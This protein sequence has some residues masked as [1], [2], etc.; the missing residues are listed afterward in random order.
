MATRHIGGSGFALDLGLDGTVIAGT[1]F[2]VSLPPVL[3]L[4]ANLVAVNEGS[5]KTVVIV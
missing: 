3:P 5:R 2:G 1:G 4:L